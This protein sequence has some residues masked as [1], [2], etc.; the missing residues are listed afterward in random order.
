[1]YIKLHSS[2]Q[3]GSV[4]YELSLLQQILSMYQFQASLIQITLLKDA[5]VQ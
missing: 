3:I 1:M 2:W 4:N 5:P